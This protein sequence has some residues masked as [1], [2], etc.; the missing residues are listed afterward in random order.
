MAM[1]LLRGACAMFAVADVFDGFADELA[2]LRRRRLAFTLR[3]PGALECFFLGHDSSLRLR[4]A[5]TVSGP[6]TACAAPLATM[7]LGALE[8]ILLDFFDNQLLDA[9]D[10]V[11]FLALEVA[12]QVLQIRLALGVGD[13]LVIAPQA[14]QAFTQLVNQVMVVIFGAASFADMFHFLFSR[15]CHNSPPR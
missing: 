8:A 9:L 6:L 4:A 3:S 15:K 12:P 14:I 1:G 10:A 2:G 11:D 5:H 13:V 7:K